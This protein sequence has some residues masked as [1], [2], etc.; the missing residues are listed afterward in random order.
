MITNDGYYKHLLPL[1]SMNHD[2]NFESEL[3]HLE[4]NIDNCLVSFREHITRNL[5][6][7]E[8][9]DSYNQA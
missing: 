9:F 3:Y 1:T 6:L 2:I 7:D 8:R 5:S 4:I